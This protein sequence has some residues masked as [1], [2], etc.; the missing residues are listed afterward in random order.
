MDIQLKLKTTEEIIYTLSRQQNVTMHSLNITD[1]T[2]EKGKI[3]MDFNAES[4]L[5]VVSIFFL[6]LCVWLIK[7]CSHNFFRGTET[8]LVTGT[9]VESLP[10]ISGAIPT[11]YSSSS[12]SSIPPMKILL[13]IA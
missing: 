9:P 1:N 4:L 3:H 13:P 10:T 7:M 2:S 12:Q 5:C 6:L 11:P 8:P